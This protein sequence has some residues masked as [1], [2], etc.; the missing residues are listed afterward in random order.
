MQ[1]YGL[2]TVLYST[3]SFGEIDAPIVYC[4]GLYV[5]SLSSVIRILFIHRKAIDV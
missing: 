5:S 1:H 2:L 4:Y 3:H